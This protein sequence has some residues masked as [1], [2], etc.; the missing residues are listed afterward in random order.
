MEKEESPEDATLA[1]PPPPTLMLGEMSQGFLSAKSLPPRVNKDISSG[2]Y[3]SMRL[4][5]LL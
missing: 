2:E 1:P 5:N 3:T 4:K